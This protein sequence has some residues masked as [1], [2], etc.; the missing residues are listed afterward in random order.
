MGCG[1]FR[2][3]C[4]VERS[5]AGCFHRLYAHHIHCKACP[6]G[7][8]RLNI[9][10]MNTTSPTYKTSSALPNRPR[11]VWQTLEEKIITR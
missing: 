5:R 1:M 10:M 2:D 8:V 11:P 9:V 3:E 7:G 6:L 4:S